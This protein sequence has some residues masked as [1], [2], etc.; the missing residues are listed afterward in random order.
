MSTDT[1]ESGLPSPAPNAEQGAHQVEQ[2]NRTDATAGQEQQQQQ[3]AQQQGEQGQ[4]DEQQEQKRTPWF[5]TRI[6]E[7]T[8]ARHEERRRADEAQQQALRYQQQLAQYQQPGSQPDDEFD[9]SSQVD[10]RTL[11]QQEATRMLAEQRFTEQCNKVYSDGKSAFPDFDQSVANLQMLGV[12]RELLELATSSDA[13]AK[14]LHHL[15]TDLDETARL[16]TLPPVQMA[17]ELT[18]LEFKLAQAPAPKPVSKAPAPIAPI[19]SATST[20]VGDTSRMSDAEWYERVH[21][22]NR[23]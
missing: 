21:M 5:Q 17:R 8:R 13:G 6:D 19:G 22:K 4:Q 7:L 10:I 1:T 11:A 20:D 14:L 23:K 9:P 15:G 18:R 2:Q 16:L 3:E 12:S